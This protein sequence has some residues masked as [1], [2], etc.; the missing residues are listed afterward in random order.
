MSCDPHDQ[1][2][3][4]AF[5]STIHWLRILKPDEPVAVPLEQEVVLRQRRAAEPPLPSRRP[6]SIGG[7][8]RQSFDSLIP[9]AW[10]TRSRI[11][12]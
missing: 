2:P 3:D 1:K 10:T 11:S 9:V 4:R 7:I 5:S 12:L 8:S 6:A